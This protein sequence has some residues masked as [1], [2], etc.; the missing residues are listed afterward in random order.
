[1]SEPTPPH[2]AGCVAYR[3]DAAG[4]PLVLMIEDQYGR[5]TLPKGHLEPGEG[6]A[7]AAQRET[8]EETG[9]SG[10]LGPLVGEITYPV[11]RR[12]GETYTKRVAFYLLRAAGD[13]LALQAEEG[14]SAAGWLTPEEA[15]A[16][17]GYEDMRGLL[18]RA[19][20]L[21]GAAGQTSE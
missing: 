14:I 5:W 17:N 6:A 21:I 10:E 3:R 18:V 7:E 11:T 4:A 19:V 16:R 2:A 8:E 13:A 1:M 9:V 15:L 12:S 20:E